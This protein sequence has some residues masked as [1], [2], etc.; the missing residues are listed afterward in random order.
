M[1]HKLLSIIL[2]FVTAA[3]VAALE[4]P[5]PPQLAPSQQQVQT[6]HLAAN[7]LKRFPYK[8]IPLNGVTSE[9]I[10]DRYLKSLDPEKLFFIQADIDR[11]SNERLKLAEDIDHGDLHIPFAMFNRYQQRVAERLG[12][13][14]ELLKQPLDFT[15]NESFQFD[16]EKAQWPK[17]DDEVRDLWRKRVKNDWLQLKLAG[18]NEKAIRDTLDK[19][20]GNL[21]SRINKT[22]GEDAFQ[23]FMDAFA[24]SVDPHTDYFSPAASADFDISMRLSLFGIGA[25]LQEKDEYT[26]IREL[27]PG[28]PAAL[29]TKLQVGDR[30]V[31]V[32]QGV[33]GPIVDVVGTRLDEV[34]KLIRGAKDSTVRLDVLPADAGPD[35]KHKMVT[36][37]RDK[38]SLDKQAAK[39]SIIQVK[40]DG[41]T[42]DVGVIT[43]PAF[44]QDFEGRRKGEK[45]FRSA[46]RDVARLLE[47]LKKDKVDAVLIDLRN[48]GGG[49]LDEA[50][51]LTGLFTGPGPV[52]QER[53]SQ[54]QIRI[55]GSNSAK[56]AWDG[57]LGVLINRGSASASEIFAAAIQDYGRGVVIGEP[58][59]GKG[60]V[61]T[62][63]DLD[64]MARNEKPTYG[65][66][67]M[68]IAQ[69]FRVNGGTTQLRGVTPDVSFPP[70]ADTERFGESS[71]DNALPW[72]QIK[73]ASYA[74]TGD[75][76]GVIPLL[77]GRHAMR[78]AQDK[79]FQYLLEDLA[80]LRAQRKKAV[81]SLNEAERAKERDLR[82]AKLK[83][84]K[85]AEKPDS[86]NTKAALKTDTPDLKKSEQQ[87]TFAADENDLDDESP[88]DAVKKN[89]KDVWLME[90]AHIVADES[91]LIGAG[92]RFAARGA[93]PARNSANDPSFR[94]PVGAN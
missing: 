23:V 17:S 94:K 93:T 14:R 71:F 53:N 8:P 38:I 15:R 12:Y 40:Q 76:S 75:M 27:V 6:A 51:A 37:V 50:V 29:S 63:I 79:D 55:D 4:L 80:E 73:A 56:R 68:T 32:G 90:A 41:V 87:D 82:E 65:G 33:A 47:E 49:S 92:T 74:P 61:Q 70:I 77:K 45:E 26:T 10:F 69:F 9:R 89:A 44:Y 34:V 30:I 81:L 1:K 28:G 19:R 35:G 22:K 24:T 16:R 20:Y 72:T 84:R 57:P 5:T 48:N 36:L 88:V 42:R 78:I 64:Q 39:K 62:I 31:G 21:L 66:L 91:E 46:T 85:A 11:F 86:G 52:V 3:N 83:L 13:A 2:A 25:V 18:K 59:F 60:T 43:L 54:G 67:K 58:S 7:I